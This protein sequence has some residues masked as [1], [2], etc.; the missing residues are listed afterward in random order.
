[1]GIA[2]P[3]GLQEGSI[4]RIRLGHFPTP[5][6]RA[7]P[8]GQQ[9][10]QDQ[11]WLK[12]DD[13]TGFSWGGNKVR[14]AEFLL[15][16]AVQ[17]DIQE[18]VVSGGPSSN[19][20]ALMTAAA[21]TVGIHVHQVSYGNRDTNSHPALAASARLGATVTFT[22]SNNRAETDDVGQRLAADR[23]HF[24]RRAQAI[25]R[26]GATPIG[27]LGFLF[28]ALELQDQI[29][30]AGIEPGAV[31]IPVGSGGSVAGLLAGAEICKATWKIVGPSVS[32]APGAMHDAVV[33]KAVAC[34]ALVGEKLD[35]TSLHQRLELFDARGPGFGAAD[36]GLRAFSRD[37][38]A[39]TGF[40]LDP[41]YN[42][43]AL[44]WLAG[45][46]RPEAGRPVIYWHTGGLLGSLDHLALEIATAPTQETSSQT[47][48]SYA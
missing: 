38:Q 24:G 10:G 35:A 42:A 4:P 5:L 32:R 9:L 30:S 44:H 43:K 6:H 40:C 18:L 31:V 21:S 15:G 34:A 47:L 45:S 2:Q 28:A 27:S 16:D 11:L 41:V 37:V 20:V 17:N 12:R 26:G 33:S 22:G 36:S 48:D 3:S 23:R 14:T 25:P 19:F 8:L 7:D 1:M 46:E 29:L 13:L 39:A